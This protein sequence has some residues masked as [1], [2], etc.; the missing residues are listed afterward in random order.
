[1]VSLERKFLLIISN[2]QKLDSCR[3][4]LF[5]ENDIFFIIDE[6]LLYVFMIILFFMEIF[7]KK[8]LVEKYERVVEGIYLVNGVYYSS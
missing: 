4:F 8:Y 6:L 1:M 7:F 3:V 2:G 5:V